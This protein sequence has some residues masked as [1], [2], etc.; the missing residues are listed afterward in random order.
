MFTGKLC[1]VTGGGSGIGKSLCEE[2]AKAG[3]GGVY[4]VDITRESAQK[5]AASLPSLATLQPNNYFRCDFGVADVGNENDIKR[6]IYDAWKSFG[7]VDVFF[8]NAGI[9]TMGG[10]DD[11]SNEQ[12]EKIWN[13]NVM[14][15]VFAAR[16]LFPLWRSRKN[17]QSSPGSTE[18]KEEEG[19]FVITASAAGLLMQI[20][21][22]PYHVT[23]HA[24]VSVADWLAVHHHDDGVRVHCICPQA[25]QTNMLASST[26]PGGGSAGLDGVLSPGDVAMETIQAIERRQFLVLPHPKVK[27]YFER[28]A[29]DYDRWLNGMRRVHKHFFSQSKL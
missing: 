9:M 28:K 13:V 5:V 16:H 17:R 14:S 19:V 29:S 22:L 11:V 23:K 26:A 2:L 6:V 24:A 1:V 20:G 8:S 25:V 15:H 27:K 10:V 12:W 18:S 4:V 7:R 3:A 21:S